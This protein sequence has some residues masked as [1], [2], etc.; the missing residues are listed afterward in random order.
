LPN[1][2]IVVSQ[3]NFPEDLA[4]K[5]KIEAEHFDEYLKSLGQNIR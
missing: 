5:I 4:A 2:S 1:P 3:N